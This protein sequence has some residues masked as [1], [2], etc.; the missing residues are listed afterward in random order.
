MTD[1][2]VYKGAECLLSFEVSKAHID[3]IF[4]SVSAVESE[5]LT[6][7]EYQTYWFR[8]EGIRKAV[9]DDLELTAKMNI[10][11]VG[12]GYG[13]FAIEMA[14]QLK[15]G[16]IVGIDIVDD[17][18]AKARKLVAK[19]KVDDVVSIFKMDATDLAFQNNCFDFTTSFLGMRDIH[20]TRG[21]KGVKKAV[22]EM[23]RVVEP[24]GKIVLCITPPEDMETEDQ[25]IAV[26]VEGKVFGAVSLPE[27]FYM[28]VFR[29][30]NVALK[31]KRAYYTK[32]KLTANQTKI[33]L[34]EG[35]E[36]AR[37]IYGREVPSFEEVWDR[38]G[39][40]IEAFGYGM[41]SKIV[42]LQG[43]KS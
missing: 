1:V 22:E 24:N 27:K 15:R 30:N 28:D 19:A 35:I 4:G 7:E 10:L 36:I 32:K 16:E 18:V 39:K 29:D 37:K 38:Y 34:S 20:M 31:E 21:R 2:L 5:Y 43:Q 6:D 13:L 26:E 40:T 14:K 9:S 42:M 41:Y 12:T 3:R 17:D 25:K 33:E 8:L 11:D 23:I